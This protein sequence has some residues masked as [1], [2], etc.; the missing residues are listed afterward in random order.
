MPVP[1]GSEG[2]LLTHGLAR[3]RVAATAASDFFMG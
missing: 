3:A 2:S 1:L